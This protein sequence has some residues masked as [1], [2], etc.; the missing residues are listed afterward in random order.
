MIKRMLDISAS[1]L[2]DMSKND[3]LKSI[4]IAEGRTISSEVITVA[5]PLLTDISNEIGR[6]HV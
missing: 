1:D 4:K 3:K 5:P 6:A 2:K